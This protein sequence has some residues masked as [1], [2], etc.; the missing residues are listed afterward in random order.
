MAAVLGPILPTYVRKDLLVS[1]SEIVFKEKFS[2][3]RTTARGE[4]IKLKSLI[5]ISGHV[6]LYNSNYYIG[7][8]ARVQL[9][10]PPPHGL[11]ECRLQCS[12]NC[13]TLSVDSS[14]GYRRQRGKDNLWSISQQCATKTLALTCT[15]QL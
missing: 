13:V 8:H 2:T 11:R 10:R 5:C 9:L 6:V 14:L 7:L 12:S 1:G 15:S 3:D 4:S